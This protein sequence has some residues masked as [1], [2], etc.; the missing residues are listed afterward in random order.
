MF[1]IFAETNFRAFAK[2]HTLM[3][4]NFQYCNEWQYSIFSILPFVSFQ[5]KVMSHL[6]DWNGIRIQNHLVRK[7]TLNHFA[8]W[9][10]TQQF[11]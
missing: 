1:H 9:L 3:R 6:S 7:R 8:Q 11:S 5:A 10:N 4:I 2:F